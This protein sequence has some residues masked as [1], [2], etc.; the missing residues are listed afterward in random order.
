MAYPF[1]EQK[2]ILCVDFQICHIV[3]MNRSSNL[4]TAH[5]FSHNEKK[6]NVC[7]DN[8]YAVKSVKTIIEELY[9]SNDICAIRIAIAELMEHHLHRG[10]DAHNEAALPYFIN[11]L[12]SLT[13]NVHSSKRASPVGLYPCLIDLENAIATLDGKDSKRFRLYSASVEKIDYDFLIEAIAAIRRSPGF[14]N[15]E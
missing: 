8:M 15:N 6:S 10:K 4:K 12:G 14:K 2:S 11:A 3:I 5:A 7:T 13:L 9:Q 1:D